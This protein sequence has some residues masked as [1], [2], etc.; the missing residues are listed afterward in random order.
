MVLTEI[1]SPAPMRSPLADRGPGATEL[2]NRTRDLAEM[3]GKQDMLGWRTKPHL[4]L[5][6]E[7]GRGDSM[8]ATFRRSVYFYSQYILEP[9]KPELLTPS[10][11]SP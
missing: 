3:S 8:K 1:G 6:G 11:L 9:L 4:S 2:L 10:A 5:V 7:T